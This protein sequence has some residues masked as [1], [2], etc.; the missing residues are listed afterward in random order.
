MK[1]HREIT[2][3]VWT[4]LWTGASITSHFCRDYGRTGSG[5][6]HSPIISLWPLC[7]DYSRV[8]TIF[9]DCCLIQRSALPA[10]I[11]VTAVRKKPWPVTGTAAH[12]S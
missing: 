5:H 10:S 11:K 8:V 9:L 3:R 12:N 1:I 4:S 2:A 6:G 7:F